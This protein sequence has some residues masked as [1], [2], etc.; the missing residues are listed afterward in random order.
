M[1]MLTSPMTDLTRRAWAQNQLCEP[2]LISDN[3]LAA[4]GCYVS[5]AQQHRVNPQAPLPMIATHDELCKDLDN[6]EL[7]AGLQHRFGT[8]IFSHEPGA[9]FALGDDDSDKCT[10]FSVFTDLIWSD[11]V[12][13]LGALPGAR[14]DLQQQDVL[15]VSLGLY[16]WNTID[17]FLH[18]DRIVI[19][20]KAVCV[21]VAVLGGG[22]GVNGRVGWLDITEN[23][24]NNN[25]TS[26]EV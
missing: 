10:P 2:G 18:T 25:I 16:A 7:L 4:L 17:L 23:N 6:S 8:K 3:D 21:R 12:L 1:T 11:T 14:S 9:L 15:F 20:D 13:G 19:D 5:T 26:W 22:E 24:N